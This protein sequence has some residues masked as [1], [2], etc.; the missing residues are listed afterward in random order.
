MVGQHRRGCFT[1]VKAANVED[2]IQLWE[3]QHKDNLRRLAAL[4]RMIQGFMKQSATKKV[5]IIWRKGSDELQFYNTEG[6]GSG[7]G[8]PQDLKALWQ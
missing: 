7:V 8:L 4:L 3:L 6:N 2:E 5:A 1:D